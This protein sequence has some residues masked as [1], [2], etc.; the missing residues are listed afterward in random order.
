MDS[1]TERLVDYTLN[2]SYESMSPNVI[3][4]CKDR[5]LDALGCL[6]GAVDHPVSEKVC[7][8]AS[9]YSMDTNATIIATGKKVA[10]EMA[11]FANSTMIRV[12]D[13]SDSYRVKSG[14]HPSDHMGAPFAAAEIAGSMGKDLM[15]AIAL[16]YEI[17]GSFTEAVDFNGQGWDQPLY[18]VVASALS[19]G[20]LLGLDREALGHA[21]ALALVPNMP[22][23][24]TRTGELTEWKG[25]AG[26]NAARNGFFAA[27]LAQEG[28]AGPEAPFEGKF[29][30]WDVV[31]KFS[32]PLEP[33]D[34]PKRIAYSNLKT[35]PICY[36]CQTAAWTALNVRD[37]FAA[38]DVEKILVETYH[39]SHLMTGSD[40]NRWAP[41]TRETADHSTPY[42][43]ATVLLQGDVGESAF[44]EE[45]LSDPEVRELMRRTEVVE[46]K[47]LTAIHPGCVPCRMTVTL[48]DGS[49]IKH[50]L[51][52]PKG[53][54][55]S[56]M[57]KQEIND[58]FRRLYANYGDARNADAVIDAVEKLDT[59]ADIA[60]LFATFRDGAKQLAAE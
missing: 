10:P 35:F 27:L 20:K 26:P 11:A 31:G 33:G 54:A 41:K 14:G 46:D 44:S 13:L 3:R 57:T 5:I 45:A 53:H 36:Q 25:C 38:G 16:G 17:Y 1:T 52:H 50:K 7:R 30:L 39:K 8:L 19:A 51:M 6:A 29:G 18:C 23:Y 58:K 60:P 2:V 40:P 4:G 48:K 12:L 22:M 9:R 24:Q 55:K 56:P 37:L 59:M 32:L 43:V 42:V 47:D 34:P 28:I 49:E 15:A 21:V